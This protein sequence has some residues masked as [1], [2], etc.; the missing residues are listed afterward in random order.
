MENREKGQNHVPGASSFLPGESLVV[1]I[2]R[3][4]VCH[5]LGG[6]HEE[7]QLTSEARTAA[8]CSTR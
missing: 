8:R 1:D 3:H 6:M 7:G 2:G 5:G 4:V